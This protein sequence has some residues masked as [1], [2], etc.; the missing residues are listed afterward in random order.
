M[1]AR[2]MRVSRS[3]NSKQRRDASS[4]NEDIRAQVVLRGLDALCDEIRR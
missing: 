4:V 1:V 2:T 3:C